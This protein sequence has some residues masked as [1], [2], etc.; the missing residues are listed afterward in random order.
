VIVD[1]LGAPQTDEF[2]VPAIY[3]DEG[4]FREVY[5]AP[6]P[7]TWVLSFDAD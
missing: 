5:I 2:L 4:R 7:T 3:S 1:Q 6:R